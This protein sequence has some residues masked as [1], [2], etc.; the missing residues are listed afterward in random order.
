[1][2]EYI[3]AAKEELLN[4]VRD[5]IIPNTTTSFEE[6]HDYVDANEYLTAVYAEQGIE[7]AN[8]VSAAIDK[9]LADGG[10]R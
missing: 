2:N 10:L 3:A 1:M 8:F 9:W 7:D 6:L 4:D 5:D